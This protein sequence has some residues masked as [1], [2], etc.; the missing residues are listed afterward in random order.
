ML[1]FFQYLGRR[2]KRAEA[3]EVLQNTAAEIVR[4]KRAA[5]EPSKV[6][7]SFTLS[8]YSVFS[9]GSAPQTFISLS[10]SPSLPSSLSHTL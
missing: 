9:K 3:L 8:L 7:S 4:L 2:S 1:G 10:L 5:K 6:G